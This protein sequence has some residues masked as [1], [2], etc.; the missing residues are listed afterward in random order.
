MNKF[1]ELC[2]SVL[3]EAPSNWEKILKAEGMIWIIFDPEPLHGES[4]LLLK[5][6]GRNVKLAIL[7]SKSRGYKNLT[8]TWN[9]ESVYDI[10]RRLKGKKFT[11]HTEP[12]K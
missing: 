1:N 11:V 5:K 7:G 9:K 6:E 10:T 4:G 8:D 2:E 3:N 12:P